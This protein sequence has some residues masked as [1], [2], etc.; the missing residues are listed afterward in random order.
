MN[1]FSR[2]RLGL[3]L[4]YGVL[5]ALLLALVAGGVTCVSIRES[6]RA[7]DAELRLF[8]EAAAA[9]LAAGQPATD[10]PERG[11]DKEDEDDDDHDRDLEHA[12]LVL[13]VLPITD[14]SLQPVA[15]TSDGLPDLPAATAAL[16]AAS[17]RFATVERRG[18]EVRL[19]SLRVA[20]DGQPV[21]VVQAARSRTAVQKAVGRLLL[22]VAL[23]GAAGGLAAMLA[24]YWLSG[25]A[26]R[27]VATALARQRAFTA[28]ASHE[29]RTPLTLLRGNA[30]LLARHPERPVGD[31]AELVQDMIDESARLGR[32]VADLLTLARAE[33]GQAPLTRQAVD[34]SNVATATI[35]D[36]EPAA[37]ARGLSLTG[38]IAPAVILQADPDRLRQLLLILLDNA[39][40]YTEQG[41]V[42]LRLA[43]EGKHVLLSVTDTGRGIAPEHMPRI[44]DRFYR[45]D[46]A[47]SGDGTGLGLAIAKWIVE[48]H[49][50]RIAVES[51]PGRGSTFTVR[52]PR[53]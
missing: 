49:G 31:S 50:G 38:D 16:S 12:G 52:L 51:R 48:A 26:L 6:G 22:A 40:R 9:R 18:G 8:A 3:M 23:I 25:R 34:L 32:L 30:E 17:G 11:R 7:D 47:R 41:S 28:D 1:E 20:R 46:P 44:W 10:S 33:A 35:R 45:A 5:I 19:Y 53:R 42:V 39:V 2:A 24:G 29:L 13:F 43:E 14:G 36:L 21:A 15:S 4:Q 27:P 37:S